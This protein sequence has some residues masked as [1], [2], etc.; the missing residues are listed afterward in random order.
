MGET[1]AETYGATNGF[2]SFMGETD[3]ATNGF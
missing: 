3:G 1:Y 2:R